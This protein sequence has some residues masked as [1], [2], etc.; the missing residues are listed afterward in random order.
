MI[1]GTVINSLN[2]Y[3][4]DRIMPGSFLRAVL[5]N[6]LYAA[7]TLADQENLA[8]LK[9]IVHYVYNELPE[10]SWGSADR[11]WAWAQEDFYKKLNDAPKEKS[12]GS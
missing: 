7:V 9:E 10:E 12:N 8:S 2:R 1:S 5:C 11:V 4:K 6:Q 3:V